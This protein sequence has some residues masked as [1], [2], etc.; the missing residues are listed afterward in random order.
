MY[1]NVVDRHQS[2]SELDIQSDRCP[3]VHGVA[4]VDNKIF[5]VYSE[6]NTIDVFN[7]RRPFERLKPIIVNDL[8]DPRDIVACNETL[9]LFIGEYG[10]DIWRVDDKSTDFNKF[11]KHKDGLWSM[12][13]NSQ[14]LLV[15]TDSWPG[16][17]CVYGVENGEQLQFIQLPETTFSHT[18]HAIESN[19]NTLF[20][21][22]R[23][24]QLNNRR[25][26]SE[27]DS[28]GQLIRSSSDQLL[29]LSRHLALDSIGSVLFADPDNNRIVLLNKQLE[30]ERILLDYKKLNTES[31]NRHQP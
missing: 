7:D 30:F 28:V 26:V 31:D 4:Q 2:P 25:Q 13:L 3:A 16:S 10:G 23:N 27:I 8:K 24:P 9:Q 6:F 20:V 14:R 5:I 29:G 21:I 1:F 22:H 15:T 18:Y 19:N 17:L 11:I 12:S